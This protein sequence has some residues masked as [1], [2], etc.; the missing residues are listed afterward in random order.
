VVVAEAKPAV[1][2]NNEACT[3]KV[4]FTGGSVA[5]TPAVGLSQPNAAIT[6]A[7]VATNTV[8]VATVSDN[9]GCTWTDTTTV[10]V[11]KA[12]CG[13]P[14]VG[15]PNLFS[16]NDDG[17]NDILKVMGGFVGEIRLEVFNRW[18]QIVFSG[19]A[20]QGWDGLMNGLP[21]DPGVYGYRLNG[22]C[23]D[24]IAFQE[25]GNITLVR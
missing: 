6:D 10:R 7:R 19:D 2:Y 11:L 8:F 16:P 25:K 20:T 21:A 24:G 1:V 9:L 17:K 23:R 3:L 18:G 5:W 14:N 12:I 13:D 15:L 22:T 4:S